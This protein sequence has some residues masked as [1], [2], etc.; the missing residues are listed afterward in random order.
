[1][2]QLQNLQESVAAVST[3]ITICM[4]ALQ[5][6][7]YMGLKYL[8]NIMNLVQF[9]IFMQMW[10]VSLPSSARI[11]L[12]ELKNLALLEFIPY[13]LISGGNSQKQVSEEIG[14]DRFGSNSLVDGFGAMLF[15]ALAILFIALLLVFLRYLAHKFQKLKH[16]YAVL[17]RKMR[18][19]ALIRY[20]L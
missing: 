6:C 13:E 8:W 2:V 14:I 4:V 18:Y 7:L 1:M 10:L 11:F 20:V 12:E 17:L 3:S 5:S 16:V 9:L 19:S 15:L